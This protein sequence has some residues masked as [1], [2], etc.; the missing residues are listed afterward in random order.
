MHD[1][2]ILLPVFNNFHSQLGTSYNCSTSKTVHTCENS[3]R[4]QLRQ[5]TGNIPACKWIR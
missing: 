2:A 3:T 1:C 5:Q 4:S